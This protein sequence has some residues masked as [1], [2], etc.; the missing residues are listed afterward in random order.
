[1]RAYL[2]KH[3]VNITAKAQ[4]FL[5]A[6]YHI[7][8]S[9]NHIKQ[10]NHDAGLFLSDLA[11]INTTN[12]DKKDKAKIDRIKDARASSQAEEAEKGQSGMEGGEKGGEARE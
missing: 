7:Q 6:A 10:T 11:T 1:M 12:M 3:G 5:S 8:F 4:I 2:Q 9:M